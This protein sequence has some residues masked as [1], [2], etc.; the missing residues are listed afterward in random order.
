ME[1]VTKI[2]AIL[3]LGVLI[4]FTGC[5]GQIQ[6]AFGK[7]KETSEKKVIYGL[8]LDVDP[9]ELELFP[10]ER[11]SFWVYLM[12]NG[13]YVAKNIVVK[14]EGTSYANGTIS[15]TE[16]APEEDYED[17]ASIT[18]IAP[19][20]DVLGESPLSTN[21]RIVAEYDYA[22]KYNLRICLRNITKT[23]FEK[24]R[25]EAGICVPQ[26]TLKIP[27]SYSP[28]QLEFAE[29]ILV[30]GREPVIGL[31][32][33]LANK[34]RGD[35]VWKGKVTGVEEAKYVLV[36]ISLFSGQGKWININKNCNVTRLDKYSLGGRYVQYDES[37]NALRVFFKGDRALIL[38]K[39][40]VTEIAEKLNIDKED[41][42]KGV[43]DIV[44]ILDIKYRYKI[45][46]DVNV[47]FY[48]EYG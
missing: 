38:C 9:T 47:I 45:W 42:E 22:T 23:K 14:P 7:E 3:F 11:V 17:D 21:F 16:L 39:L 8:E 25:Y 12:N 19:S 40:N 32:F 30:R 27:E 10:N 28:I 43:S 33:K 48:P 37:N 36:N 20:K 15:I 24:K 13:K 46:K 29:E 2:F 5:T 6:Q 44:A 18:I 1:K 26:M 41:L 31:I 4:L 35:L 34:E